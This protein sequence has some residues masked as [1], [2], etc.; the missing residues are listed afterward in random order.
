M[1]V[2]TTGRIQR[3]LVQ[4]GGFRGCWYNWEGS[5]V[6]YNRE[7]LVATGTTMRVQWLLVHP[8]RFRGCWY[9]Q[10]VGSLMAVEQLGWSGGCQH[11]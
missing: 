7:G 6:W 11:N 1:A 9:N 2:G 5:V 10:L 3:L 8:G 4:L